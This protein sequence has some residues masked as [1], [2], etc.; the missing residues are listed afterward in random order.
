MEL[1][2]ALVV[3][4]VEVVVEPLRALVV[5]VEVALGVATAVE[6]SLALAMVL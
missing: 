3:A 1:A 4:M 2:T 5:E 6:A